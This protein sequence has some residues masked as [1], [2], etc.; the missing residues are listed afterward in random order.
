[1]RTQNHQPKMLIV[2]FYYTFAHSNLTTFNSLSNTFNFPNDIVKEKRIISLIVI[3]G[4]Y[5]EAFVC[6]CVCRD[7]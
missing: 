5:V 2:I 7:T 1:M 4:F 3:K 6:V